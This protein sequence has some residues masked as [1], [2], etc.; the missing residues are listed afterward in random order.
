MRINIFRNIKIV[1]IVVVYF[2][3]S[4]LLLGNNVAPKITY[5]VSDTFNASGTWVAPNGIYAID[6]ECWGGGGGG[7]GS[8]RK[9]AYGGGGG[10]GGG[11]AKTTNFS[12]TPGQNYQVI[13]GS[14]GAG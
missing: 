6:V 9:T 14:S 5:A 13:V 7:G 3:L 12:V 1:A 2:L 11:Y 8:T 10:G 4:N